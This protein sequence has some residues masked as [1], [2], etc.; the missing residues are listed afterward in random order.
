[1][2]KKKVRLIFYDF[3]VYKE[4][5][6][7]VFYDYAT[8]KKVEI[9]D[10]REK[11]KKF[12]EK[13]KDALFI[14]YNNNFYDQ[15]I[16]KS[17]LLNMNPKEV[18]DKLISEGIPGYKIS[19]EFNKIKMYNY[20][21]IVLNKSLK[22]LEGMLGESIEETE[23]DFNLD[24]ALNELEIQK[25]LKYC[26]HDVEQTI[27]VFKATIS[28]FNAHIG[29]I[30]EFKL[31]LDDMCKTKARLASKI[32]G[33]ERL[34]GMNDEFDYVIPECISLVNYGNV[35]DW[36]LQ[37]ENKCYK[38]VN[39]KGKEVKNQHVIDVY[40][41]KHVFAFG[42]A[43]GARNKYR[44][45]G[46][47]VMSD[48]ASMYPASILLFGLLSRGVKDDSLYRK[49]RDD[50]LVL[51]AIGDPRQLPLKIVLNAVYG[52]LKDKNSDLYDPRN[53]NSICI[54][55]QLAILDLLEKIEIKFGDKCELVQTNTDGILVRLESKDMYDEYV[56][57]CKE[58][59]NRIGYELEHDIYTRVIQKDVNNY[60]IVPEGELYDEKG[61]PR[62][63]SKGA[64]VKKLSKI[65]YNLAIVNKAI[66]EYLIKD[67][68]VEDTINACDSLIEFQQVD[69][70][71]SS[72]ECIMYGDKKLNEKVIRTF[73]CTKDL[74]GVKKLK[75]DKKIKNKETGEYEL[76]DSLEKI[77]NTPERCFIDNG[78]II[79]KK[80]PEYLDKQYYIDMA[81]SRLEQFLGKGKVS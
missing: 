67:I 74:P 59:E 29:L 17:I 43:H 72:Y 24:R 69:K 57:V 62:W 48:I 42:G 21:C 66:T 73:A 45:D 4:N 37:E 51:K 23:V 3:E 35:K 38:K 68:S 9:V 77:A 81:I 26:S 44:K 33:A 58:W 7:V 2:A 36:F 27:K 61:K 64:Y 15:Y 34:H 30:N 22:Q 39:E 8:M 56:Q 32:L 75:K 25:T 80:C 63:K 12:Y 70:I 46:F 13:Y 49:I 47:F 65:D 14:G 19:K 40:G 54:T 60:V 31:P 20:D 52:I 41:V 5:W 71:G 53:S 79:G 76:K 16:F 18:N 1:M 10:D 6:M 11:F 28:E 78:N 50:R 55:G